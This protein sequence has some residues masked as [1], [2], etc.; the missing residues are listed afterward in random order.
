MRLDPTHGD[1]AADLVRRGV[2]LIVTTDPGTAAALAAKSATA[3]IPIVF[4]FE[5]D[6]N[7]VEV[8]V[9]RLRRKIDEPFD[10]PLIHTVRGAGYR[11]ADD[12]A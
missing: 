2:A 8:Y 1:S 5:G 12:D 6:P 9:R 11:I 4:N 10:H 7:I 3:T